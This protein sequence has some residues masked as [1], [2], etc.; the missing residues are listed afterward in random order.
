MRKFGQA[1]VALPMF[2]LVL[3]V[4]AA[5]MVPNGYGWA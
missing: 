2:I 3:A 5:F 1:A 4:F